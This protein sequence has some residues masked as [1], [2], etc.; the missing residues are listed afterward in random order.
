MVF[1][2]GKQKVPWNKGKGKK[3]TQTCKTCG[4]KHKEW[5]SVKPDYC[6]RECYYKSKKGK[7]SPI[8]GTKWTEKQKQKIKGRPGMIGSKNPNWKGGMDKYYSSRFRRQIRQMIKERDNFMCDECGDHRD[9]TVHHIDMD[10]RN[11]NLNNLI[12]MCRV[13]HGRL[14]GKK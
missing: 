9:L 5:P 6:N 4:Q 7:T 1:G 14:H 10:K 13:C 2:K 8:K 12:T 3:I 11:D